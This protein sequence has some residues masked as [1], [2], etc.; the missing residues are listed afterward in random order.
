MKWSKL[1][2]ETE[3][4]FADSVQGRVRVCSTRY[5]KPNSSAGRGWIEIDGKE[6]VNFSTMDSGRIWGCVYNEVTNTDC[7]THPSPKDEERTAGALAER[8]EFSRFDLH[9]ACFEY[10]NLSVESALRSRNP[11][12]VALATIDRRLGKRRLRTI[13]IDLGHPL[14]NHMLQF[15]LEAEQILDPS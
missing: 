8:G 5:R 1:K 3:A 9:E 12:I 10:L 6:V 14:P 7:K 15:R 13:G 11:L 2:Q 4:R